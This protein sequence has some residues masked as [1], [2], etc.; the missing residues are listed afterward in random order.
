MAPSVAPAPRRRGQDHG[1]DHDGQAVRGAGDVRGRCWRSP[2]MAQQLNLA[3]AAQLVGVARSTLQRM[4]G[5]GE[6][7]SFDG[8]IA[9][10]ELRRAFP[11]AALDDAGAYEKVARIRAEAFGRRV[12]E[13]LLPTQEVL[14]QRL[15]A[16]GQEMANL[17]RYLAAYHALV[18]EQER[19]LREVAC[20]RDDRELL[21]LADGMQLG[22]QRVLGTE[23][24]EALDAMAN[25][26]DVISAQ[27]TVRPSGRQFL[28]E[29]NDSIL[30]A[31][32][33]AGLRFPYGC[34]SGSCGLCKAR[35]VSGEVRRIQHADYALSDVERQ[36]GY[37]LLCTHTAVSD[38]VIESL[39]ARGPSDIPEQTVL[40]S[41]R[42][43][44]ALAPDLC[45]LHLQTPRSNRLRF[46]AGQS[47]TL[48]VADAGG[49]IVQTLPL[50]NCPC[51]ERNL[52]FHVPRDEAPLAQRLH[53]GAL[54]IG[55]T[56]SVRGP[57][58]DFVLEAESDRPL[59]L[60]ACDHGFGPI[61]SLIEHAIAAEQ[62]E[63]FALYWVARRAGGHY[64][65]NQCRAWAAAFDAFTYVP[66]VDADAGTGARR[67][68]GML[69]AAAVAPGACDVF[70]CGPEPFVQAALPALAQ[71][72]AV[73]A[74]TRALIV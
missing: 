9:V 1:N 69:D 28:L 11:A 56:V 40:A 60:F 27:V 5:T 43:V 44:T 46:L 20:R 72:G 35:V 55:A 18:I 12:R 2:D 49:D 63:S 23:P 52:H 32:L 15:F 59:L 19:Q 14:A 68:V 65:G 62:V 8:F 29:G 13:R 36:Q 45:L 42:A 16:Q 37:A 54:R 4:I 61:K 73:P 64:L 26:L 70:V 74:S 67:A 50:A 53:S 7:A 17:R 58:G 38:I 34:G 39:E 6:L 21:G 48:G 66:L 3:R 33:K 41:V 22:L 71:A 24:A 47:V 57:V 51:D 10:D 31:G 30:Q 25:M